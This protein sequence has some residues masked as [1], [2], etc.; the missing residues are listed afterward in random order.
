ME[1]AELEELWQ[2][3]RIQIL[4]LM[5]VSDLTGQIAQALDRRD[6]VSITVLLSMREDPLR[7]LTELEQDLRSHLLTLPPE[8][9]IRA[10]ELLD[11]AAAETE[12]EGRVR[13]CSAQFRRLLESVTAQDRQISLRMGGQRSFYRMFRS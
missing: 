1:R 12:E 2:R 7:R 3:R 6:E 4:R 9:A 13:D 10:R 5:E 11:G 8:D